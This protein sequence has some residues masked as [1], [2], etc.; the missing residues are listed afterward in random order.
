MALINCPECGKQVSDK[1]SA[2][3]DCGCPINTAS[4]VSAPNIA[5]E[6]AKLLVLARRARSAQDS[7]NA[8][9]CYDQILEK[10]PG[11]WEAIFYS[12]Y[13]AAI[14][15]KVMD[16]V[17]AANSVASCM[18]STFAAITDLTDAEERSA[19]I[20]DAV[21]SSLSI[22]MFFLQ[23]ARRLYQEHPEFKDAF[24]DLISRSVAAQGILASTDAAL[25]SLLGDEQERI[26][27]FRKKYLHFLNS[28][29]SLFSEEIKRLERELAAVDSNFAER[30]CLQRRVEA[31]TEEVAT[32]N[33]QINAV[34]ASQVN[35]AGCFGTFLLICGGIML[36]LGVLLT[37]M[38]GGAWPIYVAIPELILGAIFK[39]LMKGTTEKELNENEQKKAELTEQRDQKLKEL[40]AAREKLNSMNF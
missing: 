39:L 35:P 3:P 15:C 31:L 23:N 9:R 19:A 37:S 1:A 4:S 10:D 13:F 18:Y 2:C 29:T 20:D 7:V 16:M 12:V 17:P 32:L 25:G 33:D 27:A 36:I 11:N 8:K 22:A 38:D 5:E 40:A 6:V 34:A 30:L 24:S 28:N 21:A 26:V 14:G